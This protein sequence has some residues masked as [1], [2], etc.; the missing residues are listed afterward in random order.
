MW[1]FGVLEPGFYGL[2]EVK[3][4]RSILFAPRFPAEYAI[5]MGPLESL[6]KYKE[7]Y[8]V[9]EVYYVDEIND[10][11]SRVCPDML[12]LLVRL[13]LILFLTNIKSYF[14]SAALTATADL[15]LKRQLLKELRSMNFDLNLIFF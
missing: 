3:S 9:N 2:I 10:Y 11:L 6:D 13:L 8:C 4:G 1:T 15:K 7:K 14:Y 5:W 12:L